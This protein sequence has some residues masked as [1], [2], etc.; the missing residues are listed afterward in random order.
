M[1]KRLLALI[2]TLALAMSLLAVPA[3]AADTTQEAE[4]TVSAQATVATTGT[5]GDNVTWSYSNGTLT[6]SGTGKMYDYDTTQDAPW[7]SDYCEY[8]YGEYYEDY[9][10]DRVTAIVVKSGVTYIGADAFGDLDRVTSVTLPSTVTA[11]GAEAFEGLEYLT[12]ITL[13]SKLTTIGYA[14]FEDCGF[15]AITIPSTVTPLGSAAFAECDQLKTR[16]FQGNAPTI[17]TNAFE[18]VTATVNYPAN[19]ST[20]TTANMLNYGGKLTWTAT[21]GT[22]TANATSTSTS[23]TTGDTSTGTSTET[24]TVATPTLS[25]IANQESGVKVTW[26]AV[27]GATGYTIHR[28][29]GSGSWSKVKTITNGTTTSW[30]NDED[31]LTSG[32]TYTYTVRAYVT[33]NG[34]TTTSGYDKTGLTIKWLEAPDLD[35]A[36][37]AASSI[38]VN[39][40]KVKGASGY[41]IYRKAGSAT[42]WTKVGTVKSGSTLKWS[43]KNVSN[44]TKYTYMVKAYSG[45]YTSGY[46]T[47]GE[48]I[49]RLSRTSISSLKNR[50]SKKMTVK[51]KK[52]SKATGYQIQYSTNSSFKNAKTVKVTS[53][54]SLSK[55][56]SGL[57]KGKKYYVRVRVYKTT[58]GET[59]RSAWS[60]TK[61]V[62]IKK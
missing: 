28:K 31:N 3:M 9:F 38:T 21:G 6:I 59:Y 54:S 48:V 43:D 7:S 42:K 61:T 41:Y 60:A 27:S 13:P 50:S 12:S 8:N 16:T 23:T 24:V 58:G 53:A 62:T 14:A 26:T 49:Y 40:E 10:E 51:W 37:N 56:I 46:E 4:T 5:C 55:T 11:I 19:D 47:D 18:D 1:K 52:N 15:T 39:W 25:K 32:T 44:G 17:G 34:T 22:T 36:T 33:Q 57:T 45:S 29:T 35:D 30:V 2:L 20:W